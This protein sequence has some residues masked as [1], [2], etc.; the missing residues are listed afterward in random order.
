[1][2][3]A[4]PAP[5][6]Q[7]GTAVWSA[8][9]CIT[10]C[11]GSWTPMRPFIFP[12]IVLICRTASALWD[13]YFQEVWE[14]EIRAF[15]GWYHGSLEAKSRSAMLVQRHPHSRALVK[16]MIKDQPRPPSY[17]ETANLCCW[18]EEK[19]LCLSERDTRHWVVCWPD[20]KNIEMFYLKLTEFWKTWKL[21]GIFCLNKGKHIKLQFQPFSSHLSAALPPTMFKA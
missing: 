21:G 17:I 19:S 7:R 3:S 15:E 1:M 14:K 4:S 2:P 6:P 9:N 12:A 10:T 8:G 11:Q 20:I 18:W 16:G 5:C 13:A